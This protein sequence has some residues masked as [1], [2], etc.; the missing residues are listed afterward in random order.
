MPPG[1]GRRAGCALMPSIVSRSMHTA[2]SPALFFD[3]V[4]AYQKSAAL[5]AAIEIGLFTAIGKE[6]VTS[7]D[8]AARCEAAE[9]GVRILADYLTLS[10]FLVKEGGRYSLTADSAFFLDRSSP[11]YCGGAVEFLLDPALVRAFDH[12][13]CVV[14]KG[15]SAVQDQGTIAPEHP[16]W[17]KFARAMAPMMVPTAR[18]A[19]GQFSLPSDRPTKVLDIAAGHGVYG[20]SFAS[21]N[22]TCHVTAL[23]WKNVLT[24]AEENARAAEVADRFSTIPGD[25]FT[26]DLGSDYD[27]ILVP[28]FLH[29]FNAADCTKFL[30]RVHAALRPG[31]RV[32]IIEFVPNDDRISPHVPASFA[33]VMLGSTPEGDA[34][35]FAEYAQMLTAAGFHSPAQHNL[36]PTPQA[37]VVAEK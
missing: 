9:R 30:Q 31:G 13:G 33:L 26:A 28:N 6:S 12:L 2:P 35:T 4:N 23:D 7:A 3:S 27:L 15:G 34:Y 22:P 18:I 24:V 19:A 11:A 16:V 1:G 36:L 10:G 5:K 25:A 14:K 20:I 21:V 17:E 8:L 32:L 37:A 29:H